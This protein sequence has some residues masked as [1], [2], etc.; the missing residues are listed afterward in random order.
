MNMS[1]STPPTPAIGAPTPPDPSIGTK[2]LL[3][4]DS[5]TGKTE[6][7]KTLIKA[8]ITPFCIATEQNFVQTMQPVLGTAAHYCYIAPQPNTQLTDIV[9]MLTKVNTLSYENLTK[10]V[11]P[12]RRVPQKIHRA[13]T[14]GQQ[15]QVYVLR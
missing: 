4:G 9:D 2:T 13:G 15:L 10:T 11:D 1:T 8:G 12:F 3:L 14:G 6:S 5:G 7:I